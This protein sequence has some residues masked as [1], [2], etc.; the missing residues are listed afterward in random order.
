M[1]VA[2]PQGKPVSRTLTRKW[3]LLGTGISTDAFTPKGAMVMMLSCFLYLTVQVTVLPRLSAVPT[4][5]QKFEMCLPIHTS[6]VR[7]DKQ[8]P[9]N[10][11]R[12]ENQA[13]Q[14]SVTKPMRSMLD[15][16]LGVVGQADLLSPP[17]PP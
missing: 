8:S 2:G 15:C 13:R 4:L 17:A 12:Q 10:Q 5:L 7:I 9:R 16:L 1:R 6:H 3:D 14:E 11:T